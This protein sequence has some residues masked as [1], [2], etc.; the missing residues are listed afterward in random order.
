MDKIRVLD[1]SRSIRG[2][3]QHQKYFSILKI[4]CFL[5]SKLGKLSEI[6]NSV[7]LIK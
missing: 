1:L 7:N 3:L 2:S 5:D 6:Q 4:K